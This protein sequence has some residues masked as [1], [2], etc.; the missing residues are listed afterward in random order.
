MGNW[1]VN[2]GLSIFVILVWLGMNVFLFV[3]Y[4]RVYDNGEKYYYT[5]K[6]LGSALALARAP[7]ACL[8]FNCMLIL[9][10]VCRNLLS[11]LRGSSAVRANTLLSSWN[12]QSHHAKRPFLGTANHW[13]VRLPGSIEYS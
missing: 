3:W 11:F 5:R 12:F 9:L 13:S 6:L 1:A 7:A 10:P 4:Y 8:N 2:E